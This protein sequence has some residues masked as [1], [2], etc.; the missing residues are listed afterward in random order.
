MLL[1]LS[2]YVYATNFQITTDLLRFDYTEFSPSGQ[3]LDRELGWLPGFQLKATTTYYGVFDAGFELS[4]H[5]GSINYNGITSQGAAHT[6][7]T[8]EKITRYGIRVAFAH[9]SPTKIF[10]QT[11]FNQWDR[12]IRDSNGVSGIFEVYRWWEISAGLQSDIW[13]S[14]HYVISVEAS[15]LRIS[16]PVIFV[17]F[18]RINRGTAKLQMKEKSGGR[19]QLAWEQISN[20]QWSYKLNTYLEFWE[21]G[22]S[23]TKRTT[24]GF[25]SLTITEPDSETR[26]LGLQLTLKYSFK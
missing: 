25:S 22:R 6:T 16:D 11:R 12:D 19:L 26:N 15:L 24:G 23:N 17:D 9:N 21:F 5:K 20:R 7:Q 8:G 10:G 3:R 1:A 2:G 18:S 13:R 4:Q 14:S